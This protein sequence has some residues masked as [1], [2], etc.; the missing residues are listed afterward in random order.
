[1]I[2]LTCSTKDCGGRQQMSD[3]MAGQTVICPTCLMLV[4]VPGRGVA[5]KPPSGLP[6]A[7]KPASKPPAK[8]AVPPPV[9]IATPSP[10]ASPLPAPPENPRRWFYD[11]NGAPCGPVAESDLGA[12]AA[13]D[14]IF[15]YT[16][17]W[18]EAQVR[19]QPAGGVLPRLFKGATA[20][21][22]RPSISWWQPALGVG[23]VCVAMAAV[24]GAGLTFLLT[25]QGNAATS[26]TRK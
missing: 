7:A 25:G 26:N 23:M 15:P 2:S 9:R 22:L 8:V 24:T 13:D 6:V 17:V 21:D 12:L 16:L 4:R 11:L 5:A 14:R 10:V 19:W 20:D 18:T 1:M 3:E